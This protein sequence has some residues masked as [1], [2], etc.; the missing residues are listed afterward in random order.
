MRLEAEHALPARR[1][2]HCTRREVPLPQALLAAAQREQVALLGRAQV[3]FDAGAARLG[4][5]ERSAL[6]GTA[7]LELRHL[8]GH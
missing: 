8:G 2:V 7:L 6:F 1:Q 5:L 4:A 3:R